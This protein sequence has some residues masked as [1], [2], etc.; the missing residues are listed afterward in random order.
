MI[1]CKSKISKQIL[2]DH[3]AQT[4][5]EHYAFLDEALPVVESVFGEVTVIVEEDRGLRYSLNAIG[6]QKLHEIIED[7]K[8]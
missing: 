3:L 5:E 1:S 4:H 8:K 6:R 2:L 7:L